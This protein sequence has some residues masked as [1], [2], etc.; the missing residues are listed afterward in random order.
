MHQQGRFITKREDQPCNQISEALSADLSNLNDTHYSFILL[1][2]DHNRNL[3]IS[4]LYICSLN[5]AKTDDSKIE[6]TQSSMLILTRI[7]TT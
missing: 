5:T 6:G 7:M 3:Q 1:T 4:L 2:V